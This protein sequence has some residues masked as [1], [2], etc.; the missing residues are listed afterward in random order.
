MLYQREIK[1][2]KNELWLPWDSSPN[3]EP[4]FSDIKEDPELATQ[5]SKLRQ[6]SVI[7]VNPFQP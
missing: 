7:K 4:T 1:S 5:V 3:Q 2:E 6:E